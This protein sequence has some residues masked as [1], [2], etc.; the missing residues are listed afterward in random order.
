MELISVFI[1]VAAAMV[2]FARHLIRKIK[3]PDIHCCNGACSTCYRKTKP[4]KD[5]NSVSTGGETQQYVK[6]P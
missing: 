5:K 6:D 3:A 2:C 1:I 4:G